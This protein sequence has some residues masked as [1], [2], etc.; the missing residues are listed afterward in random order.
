MHLLLKIF[1]SLYP[2]YVSSRNQS[3]SLYLLWLMGNLARLLF[4]WMW[5]YKIAFLLIWL[6]TEYINYLW[7]RQTILPDSSAQEL[8]V[9]IIHENYIITLFPGYMPYHIW[10]GM[11]ESKLYL[12]T[13]TN[14]FYAVTG[15]ISAY[16]C[17]ERNE[18]SWKNKEHE[19]T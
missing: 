18:H 13:K 16:S 3:F 7:I 14:V 6:C 2:S 19:G 8:G 1:V 11:I 10:E 9:P 12:S 4:T 5:L 17:K 15:V